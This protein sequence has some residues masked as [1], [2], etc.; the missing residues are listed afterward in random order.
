MNRLRKRFGAKTILVVAALAAPLAQ[1]QMAP[2]NNVLRENDTMVV[3]EKGDAQ[4]TGRIV[5]PTERA[6][7]TIKSNFPNP[8]VLVRDLLGSTGKV[9]LK[10][11]NVNYEDGKHALSVSTTMLGAA[12][13]QR[14]KW[15]IDAGKGSE[16]LH[17][18]GRNC[19]MMN[20]T[21]KDGMVLVDSAKI[22]LP[23]T[24]K[25]IKSDRETGYLTYELAHE[26]IK[27]EVGIDVI[28]RVDSQDHRRFSD[29]LCGQRRARRN[30]KAV[31]FADSDR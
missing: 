12:V 14:N 15:K 20:V 17:V 29:I 10:D 26:P 18:D 30:G 2:R 8:N 1:A 31:G 27:G 3:D 28:L 5:F 25:N 7:S 19:V 21:T 9:S 23:A 16:L 22:Q 6:Y 24:A 11:S 4:F 13:N